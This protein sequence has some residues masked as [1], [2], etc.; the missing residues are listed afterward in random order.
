[1][2]SGY[3]PRPSRSRDML[4][5]R[6][7]VVVHVLRVTHAAGVALTSLVHDRVFSILRPPAASRM[8]RRHRGRLRVSVSPR[9]PKQGR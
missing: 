1:M 3:A 5:A 6:K 4:S 9:R 2:R 7:T 8:Q